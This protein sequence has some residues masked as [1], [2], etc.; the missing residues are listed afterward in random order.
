MRVASPIIEKQ[1]DDSDELPANKEELVVPELVAAYD[2][3]TGRIGEIIGG[4]LG[5]LFDSPEDELESK[6]DR[7]EQKLIDGFNNDSE[8]NQ[9][10]KEIQGAFD[11]L[12][13][14]QTTTS[15]QELSQQLGVEV[16]YAGD[17]IKE[18]VAEM[19]YDDLYDSY[20]ATALSLLN[21]TAQSIYDYADEENAEDAVRTELNELVKRSHWRA[22]RFGFTEQQLVLAF[23]AEA[24]WEWA[25]REYAFKG[26]KTWHISPLSPAPCEECIKLDGEQVRVGENFSNGKPYPPYHPNCYCYV[27]YSAERKPS[28]KITC[29]KCGRFLMDL[30][31]ASIDK[32]ICPNTKCKARL[33]VDATTGEAPIV[34]EIKEEG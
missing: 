30:K 27:E 16:S 10:I 18:R 14:E 13:K 8:L 5:D 3:M 23:T 22:V 15:E 34:K 32:M 11:K 12:R 29:P 33:S 4:E 28:R 21:F 31:E 1:D 20:R 9:H 19:T 25:T 24:L 17:S 2:K 7:L 6:I 26:Y